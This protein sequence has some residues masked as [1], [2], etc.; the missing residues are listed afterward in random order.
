M[1]DWQESRLLNPW[2]VTVI[3][4]ELLEESFAANIPWYI[5]ELGY[6]AKELTK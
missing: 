1:C 3:Q 2:S 4:Q 5:S 6:M